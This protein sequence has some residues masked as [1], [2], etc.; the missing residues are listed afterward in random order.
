MGKLARWQTEGR[1]R[2]HVRSQM[3]L[4][5]GAGTSAAELMDHGPQIRTGTLWKRGKEERKGGQEEK[6]GVE[7]WRRR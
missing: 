4:R 7:I 6:G 2:R 1:G 5:R 3:N